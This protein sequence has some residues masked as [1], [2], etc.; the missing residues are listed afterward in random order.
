MLNPA[1]HFAEIV[2]QAHAVVLVGGTMQPT[3]G[4]VLQLFP[5]VPVGRVTN[6]SCGHVIPPQNLLP[7]SV[8]R[9]PSGVT[10]NFNFK[11]RASLEQVS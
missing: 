8:P 11:N 10:F 6:Y 5:G 1:I 4:M 2:A 9:G 7:L 3:G